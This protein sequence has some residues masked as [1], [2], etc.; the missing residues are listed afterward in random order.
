[1]FMM[2]RSLDIEPFGKAGLLERRAFWKGSWKVVVVMRI[3]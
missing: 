3:H 2:F 1:M